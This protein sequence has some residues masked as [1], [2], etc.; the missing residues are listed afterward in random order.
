[1]NAPKLQ[2]IG[3]DFFERP[4]RLRLPFRFGVVTLREAP[5]MFVRVRIRLGD[6]RE[7]EG[8]SADLLVPKWF[9]KSPELSNEQNFDQLRRSLAMARHSLLGAGSNTPFGLSATVDGAHHA[10]CAAIGLNGLVAS[11]GLA[12]IDRAIIDA[13]GRL[14]AKSVFR[15][16]RENTLGLNAATAADLAGFDFDAFLARLAPAQSIHV[17]HT[18]GLVDALTSCK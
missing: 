15:L 17:R 18:V 14:Q 5:Q 12:L 1:M 10:A 7:G 11:Y 4:V 9:D 16:A 2:L 6:G 8:G 3:A 13:L